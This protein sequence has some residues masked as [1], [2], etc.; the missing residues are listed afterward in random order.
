MT[1]RRQW[2]ACQVGFRDHYLVP[3]VLHQGG[4]LRAA[5][6]EMWVPPGSLLHRLGGARLRERYHAE[7]AEAPVHSWNYRTL[8]K[9]IA[10]R[11]RPSPAWERT[12]NRNHWFQQQCI[13]GLGKLSLPTSADVTLFAYSYAARRI[14]EYARS[15]GWRTVLGQIDPGRYDERLM[16]DLYARHS[17]VADPWERIPEEY[18]TE[19]RRE[20]DIADRIVVNSEW[21]RDAL[22][23]E[24]VSAQKLRVI[25]LAYEAASP[26]QPAGRTYPSAFSASRPLR[27]LLL[28]YVN[29]RKGIVE[30]LE[31]IRELRDAPIDVTFVGPISM[32]I[33]TEW[34]NDPR[35][36]WVGYL[37]RSEA[38]ERYRDADVFLFPSHSDGFGLT[39]LEAQ[40]QGLPLIASPFSGRVVTHEKNGLLLPEVSGSAIAAALRRI[41][42]NPLLLATFSKS[43]TASAH[44]KPAFS[45]ALLNLD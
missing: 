22:V 25:P 30:T 27:V 33:P 6:T 9:E 43:A 34:R 7:L 39:Q 14:L 1:H 8:A 12:I 3:R 18:W 21:S 13:R 31:A 20:C 17:A 45:S 23:R 19:W 42:E 16:I 5:L 11:A 28:G 35:L 24:G 36:H 40:A 38:L 2:I 29:V 37:P 32:R 44:A 41:L 10:I 4:V 26:P 15:R